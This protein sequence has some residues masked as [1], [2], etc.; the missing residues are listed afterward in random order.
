MEFL[1]KCHLGYEVSGPASFLFNVAVA[2]NSFQRITTEH[3]EGTR[4]GVQPGDGDRRPALPPGY[5]SDWS[6]RAG[7]GGSGGRH[8]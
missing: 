7:L 5:C 3:F 6:S 4:G 8:T 2:Q 1:I